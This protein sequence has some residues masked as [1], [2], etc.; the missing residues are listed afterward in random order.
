MADELGAPLGRRRRKDG[1][2]PGLG[3]TGRF[4]LRLPLARIGFALVALVLVGA[5]LRI[6]LINDPDGGRPSTTV[7]IS[8][9]RDSNPVAGAVAAPAAVS[10]Q[11]ATITAVPAPPAG[12]PGGPSITIVDPDLPSGATPLADNPAV[13]KDG[14]IADLAEQTKDGPIPRMSATGQTPFA[15][16]SRP[17]PAD[18]AGSGRSM[19]AIVVTGLGL[20][21]QGTLDAVDKL[22]PEID[23]AFAP[24]G[25][26][27]ARTVGAARAA[28][29]ELLLQV[30]MEPF[31]YPDT[32]PGPQ[33]LLTGQPSR[34][35]LDK[36]DWLMARFG[37][38]IGLINNTGARFTASSSDFGPVMEELGTRGL[39]YL[40]DGTSN[41]SV[42][43]DLATANKVPFGRADVMLDT[44][45]ARAP[46]LAALDALAAKAITNGRAIGVISA[47]PVSIATV[48]EWSQS[49]RGRNLELVPV[50][51]LMK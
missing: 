40:D 25:K 21:E 4:V 10:S 50:S 36:L 3:A 38:Y 29:H 33:T 46:I 35:N 13:N 44:N 48:A 45:P 41:R 34:S 20:N 30:P 23:M 32:D 26:S 18:A 8:S 1:K 51:A 22:P 42:A 31:D 19:I 15:A 12:K 27:L 37:G 11:Q 39:G 49:L 5:V 7:A 16:Y 14:V 43:P 17:L 6:L 9:T 28:G 24:Y 47:L 2:E